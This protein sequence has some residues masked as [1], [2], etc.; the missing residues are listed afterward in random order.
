MFAEEV[1]LCRWKWTGNSV[2][3]DFRESEFP[4]DYVTR[5]GNAMYDSLN[6]NALLAA[7]EVLNT[8]IPDIGVCICDVSSNLLY[9]RPYVLFV[10]S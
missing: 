3:G 10:I 2:R 9:D 7:A 6:T 5:E 1:S 8:G 4:N